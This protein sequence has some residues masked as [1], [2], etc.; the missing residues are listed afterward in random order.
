EFNRY[1]RESTKTVYDIA[2]YPD[3]VMGNRISTALKN[4]LQYVSSQKYVQQDGRKTDSS[5]FRDMQGQMNIGAVPSKVGVKFGLVTS[6]TSQRLLPTN[7]ALYS[8]MKRID[9]DR[10]Q[11]SAL[12]IGTPVAI[13]HATRDG[14]WIYVVAPLCEGWIKAEDVG[15]CSREEMASYVSAEPFVVTTGTKVDLFLDDDLRDHHAYVRMGCR[16][17]TKDAGSEDISEIVLPFRGSDGRCTFEEAYVAGSDV[18]FGY[19]PYTP[20]TIILQAFKLLN[21]PYGW[22]DMHGEQDCSRF[23]QEIFST[24]GIELP[25]NSSQQARVGRLIARFK[26]DSS[27]ENRLDALSDNSIGGISILQ[28]NGHIMLFLGNV[29]RDPYAIHDMRGYSESGPDGERLMVVNRVVVSNLRIG[30]GTRS[31]P[32]LKRLVT[33]RAFEI[34]PT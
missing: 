28:M 30:E 10:L 26:G 16:F 31:G 7:A 25:R 27:E 19:L 6:F 18:S 29:D 5:F 2:S 32:F 24:V 4:T 34:G 22:G 1:I 14:S 13:L 23:I 17:P 11:N 8:D 20:R 15:L 12:D 9:I 3:T 33:V 21:F